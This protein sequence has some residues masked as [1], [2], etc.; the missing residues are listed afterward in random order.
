MKLL[1]C[2]DDSDR[3]RAIKERLQP[4]SPKVW[5]ND[6]Q[7]VIY[8]YINRRDVVCLVISDAIVIISPHGA[9]CNWG[10]IATMPLVYQA[11]RSS[12]PVP[13]KLQK[14]YLPKETIRV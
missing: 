12:S 2:A 5:Y 8:T 11:T 7:G 9:L 1:P 6:K 3:G 4:S 10:H 14:A 13:N